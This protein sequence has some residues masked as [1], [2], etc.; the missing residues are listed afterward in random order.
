MI[1][2]INKNQMSLQQPSVPA[3]LKDL[4]VAQDIIDTLTAH[5]QECVGM[6][7]NMINVHKQIIVVCFGPL[8]VAMLNPQIISKRTPYQT[9]EGCLSLTGERSV[10]RYRHI[11]VKFMNIQGQ[12]QTLQL[13]NFA[14]QIVQHEVDHCNGILI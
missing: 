8:K 13:D 14:A 6:A 9:S 3:T 5:E 4:S 7:A 1:K 12:I 2:P 11:T 10:Q